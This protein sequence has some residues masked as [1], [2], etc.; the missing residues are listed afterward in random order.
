MR[1]GMTLLRTYLNQVEGDL[2]LGRLVDLGVTA[3]LATDNCGGMRPHF[4]LQAGVR[5]LVA[6]EDLE[7]S[8]E[9]LAEA[10]DTTGLVAWIC[11]ACGEDVEGNFDT[12]WNCGRARD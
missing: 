11:P 12:C 2:A 5:L 9:I 7:K 6:D 10:D 8:R 3:V 4:D 1:D